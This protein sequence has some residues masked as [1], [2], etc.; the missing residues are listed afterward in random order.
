M[1]E[2]YDK[3][4][5]IAEKAFHSDVEPAGYIGMDHIV[6]AGM[7]G[8]GAL[9]SIFSSILSKTDIHVEVVKGY[10]LPKTANSKS[11]VVATSISGDT[12]ETLAVLQSAK[13]MNCKI[14]AFSS[15]GK[16]QEFC[17]ENDIMYRKFPQM[18]SPRASFT[19]FLYAMLKVLGPII[20]IDEKD[21][22]ESLE[23]LKKIGKKISS[24]NLSDSN[25]AVKLAEW[26]D[27]IPMIYYPSGLQAAAIRFKNSLQENSKMHAIVENVIEACHNGIVSWETSSEVKP[28][29]IQGKDD[30]IKTKERWNIIK[31][32]FKTKKIEYN[33]ILSIE[34]S[35]LS[36]LITL[37]YLVDY[38][39]IY[40]A[41]LSQIDPS[42]IDSI[43]FIKSRL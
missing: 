21:I 20:P 4:P 40:R 10:L 42:P 2:V 43:D 18:H 31:D 13:K 37:I 1:H 27:G 30:Y 16:M 5:E 41:V 36:K 32:Y 23:E 8:S 29:L 6:F 3:W 35:I 15:G 11:L 25:P 9:S 26:I 39:T 33:E 22:L 34:G 7:G 38:A 17:K 28:I 24:K 12:K 14:I 19:G